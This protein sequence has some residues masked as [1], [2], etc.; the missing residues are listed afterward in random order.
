MSFGFSLFH[1][2]VRWRVEAGEALD[3]FL[4]PRLEPKALAR[5]TDKLLHYNYTLEFTT[6]KSQ[7][8]V[9]DIEG[10]PIQVG[11]YTTEIGFSVPCW[12]NADGAIFCARQDAMEMLEPEWM[13]FYDPQSNEWVDL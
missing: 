7:H 11:I 2:E 8:F 13:T 3:A 12:E 9:K 1:P 6:E 5:F 10:V 4:H